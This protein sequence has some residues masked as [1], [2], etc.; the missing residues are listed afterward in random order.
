LV[1]KHL[2]TVLWGHFS[3]L[4]RPLVLCKFC[5]NVVRMYVRYVDSVDNTFEE[6]YQLLLYPNAVVAISKGMWAV[7]LLHQQNPPVLNWRCWLTRVDLYNDCKMVV[8]WLVV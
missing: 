7:K 3:S 8:G 6:N 4:Y 2:N 1:F 5:V